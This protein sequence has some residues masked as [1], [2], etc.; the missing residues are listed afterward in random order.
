M[1]TNWRP[2]LEPGSGTLHE[3]LLATLR[4]DIA[5]GELGAGARMPTHRE[6]AR[7]LGIGVGTV[8]KLYAEAE[9]LGLLTSRVGR[10]TFVA[11]APT[12]I[13][14]G[15]LDL[16]LNLPPSGPAAARLGETL[17]RLSSRSDLAD[18]IAIPPQPGLDRHRRA[19]AEWLRRWA[20]LANVDWRRIL[21]TSGA[22]HGMSLALDA[23][24]RPGETILT[25]AVTFHGASAIADHRGF[26]LAGL[27][28][29]GEGLIPD[30]LE[31]AVL[32]TGARVV[33]VQPTLQNPTARSMS[34]ARREAIVRIARRHD[35]WL[36]ECDV[37]S[38]LARAGAARRG[39]KVEIVPIASLAPERTLYA[40]SVSKSFG[41]G[42]RVGYL[43]APSEALFDRLCLGMRAGIYS[44][45]TLG[46]LVASEWIADGSADD[47]VR[48]VAGE[49]E[50]RSAIA[51]RALGTAAEQPSHPATLHLWLPMSELAAE[52]TAGRLLRQG[53]IVTPP[54]SFTIAGELASGLRLCLGSLPDQASLDRALG[55]VSAILSA[56]S[57]N[58]TTPV[59]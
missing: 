25:D 3:R 27:A 52:R 12:P 51:L 16:T 49:A 33:Y 6:L 7:T 30:A 18:Y 13:A 56:E 58:L 26:T 45:G 20:N 43:V 34:L 14:D 8:S 40:G 2:S 11:T 44:T 29:D 46:P 19:G 35:L 32:R 48:E 57:E 1:D 21:V 38:P 59:I 50:H 53:L 4:G 22:Q 41:A 5:A 23:V 47:I 9:R 24:C 15:P 39:E 42:L 54:S 36:L 10:G 37:Y 17:A 31:D 55:A 28:M